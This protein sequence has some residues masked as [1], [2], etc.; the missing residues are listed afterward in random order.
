MFSICRWDDGVGLFTQ[1]MNGSACSAMAFT[2]LWPILEL[3][4]NDTSAC[5]PVQLA[6]DSWAD[7]QH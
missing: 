6:T 2:E 3:I 7:T 1:W 4:L 5:P